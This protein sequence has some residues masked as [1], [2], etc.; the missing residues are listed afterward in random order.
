MFARTRTPLTVWFEAARRTVTGLLLA[1]AILVG[2][3]QYGRV[4]GMARDIGR[5]RALGATRS[6]I[7]LQVLINADLCGVI[8][9]VLGIAVGLVIT[10]V[11][12]G[13]LPGAG[14]M[15][16]AIRAARLDPV[17]ILRVP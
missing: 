9:S 7:V 2:A 11:V 1:V 14:S 16:P 5:C 4:A 3:L 6:T 17:R 12:A 15:A 8:G 13:A 10:A